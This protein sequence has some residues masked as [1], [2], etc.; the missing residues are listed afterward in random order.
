M[1]TGLAFV[2]VSLHQSIL[3]S[4]YEL[5]LCLW[6]SEKNHPNYRFVFKKQMT[7]CLVELRFSSLLM[8]VFS[9][10]SF[11]F[12]MAHTD[13]WKPFLETHW[14]AIKPC[15][16]YSSSNCLSSC[17]CLFD[18]QSKMSFTMPNQ[19]PYPKSAGL[20][21]AIGWIHSSGCT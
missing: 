20:C 6:I 19:A 11:D 15:Y 7:W 21:S 1:T 2:I 3:V 10:T 12:C 8:E 5:I 13:C 14:E 16:L 9:S 4:F 17:A 18:G